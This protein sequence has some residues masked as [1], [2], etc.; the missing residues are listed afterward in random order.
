VVDE[1]H[2]GLGLGVVEL[3]V[4]QEELG[5]AL[6]PSPFLS[7]T[8][9]ALLV[10]AAGSD[11]QKAELLAPLARGDERGAVAVWDADGG[12]APDHSEL[13]PTG[14]SLSGTK[15]AVPDAGS[16]DW[17]VVAAS[18][19][20]HYVV[21]TADDGVRVEPT[22]GIDSTRKLYSVHL[23]GA[24][25][26]HLPGDGD[27]IGHAY[28]G[29]AAA[30]AA[31]SVGVAQRAL[32]MSVEYANDR[33]QFGRPIGAYQAVSHRCA[34]MLLETEGARSLAYNAGWACDHDP[35][36]AAIAAS[37][38]KAYASEAGWRVTASALQVHGGIGFTWEHDL[39]FFLKRAKA[40]AYAFGD[41]KWHRDRVAALAGV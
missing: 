13:E 11:E 4:L 26:H 3:V 15:I 9:A 22:P 1:E 21:R 14:S 33:K 10:G 30:L 20:R 40:N 8:A 23:D 7:N 19:G 36:S 5:Y 31:E 6:A 32:E 37:M 35:G 25:A 29:I 16:A 34:Q 18:E 41:P 2:D 12:W 38:A 39:H 24:E 28:H 17:I 27:A